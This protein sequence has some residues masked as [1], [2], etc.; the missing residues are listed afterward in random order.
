MP[1]QHATDR[2]GRDD[3]QQLLRRVFVTPNPKY[4]AQFPAKMPFRITITLRDG[5]VFN[6]EQEDYP[7]F[8]TH[9]MSW[10]DAVGKFTALCAPFA[11]N[12]IIK[13]FADHIADCENRKPRDL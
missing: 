3:V 10:Q 8:L 5:S 1:E 11:S 4:S 7:G 13:A 2:I 6:R 12:E 9:P